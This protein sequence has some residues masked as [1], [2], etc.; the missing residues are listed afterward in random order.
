ML[1]VT[2]LV[3]LVALWAFFVYLRR[4]QLGAAGFG[5]ATLRTVGVAALLLLL[6]NP[7]WYGRSA[8]GAP[9]V[10]LD[11]SLSM[12][13]PG[14]RWS[15]AHDTAVALSGNAR[16]IISFGAGVAPFDTMPPAAPTTRLKDALDVGRAMGGPIHVV[17]DGEI[18][19][20]AA[21]P[22]D[23]L[24]D[25]T[26]VILPRDTVPDAALLDVR[27]QDRVRRADSL[28]VVVTIGTWGHGLAQSA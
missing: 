26:F 22:P 3:L 20:I 9:V 13:V 25:V 23:A 16:S 21:I 2:L 12:G 18:E 27:V 14:G 10:L 1:T 6:V 19:D 5:M 24:R 28:D 17:S 8:G 11:G 7:E 4:E 15:E